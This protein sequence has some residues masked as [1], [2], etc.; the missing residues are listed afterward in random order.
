MAELPA[1]AVQTVQALDLSG[2]K[3]SS[4]K[5][6]VW[7]R[8][9]GT[10]QTSYSNVTEHDKTS[11]ITRIIFEPSILDHLKRPGH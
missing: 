7:W 6:F 1:L 3:F 5:F 8:D 2:I 10:V 11:G 4:V 9:G